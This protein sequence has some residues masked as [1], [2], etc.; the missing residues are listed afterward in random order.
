RSPP[1]SIS[2]SLPERVGPRP[3][4]LL[5]PSKRVDDRVLVVGRNEPTRPFRTVLPARISLLP[6]RFDSRLHVKRGKE[7][8]FASFS[9]PLAQCR[10]ELTPAR[11]RREQRL[12]RDLAEDELVVAKQRR[13]DRGDRARSVEWCQVP[14]LDGAL[15]LLDEPLRDLPFRLDRPRK[16]GRLHRGELLD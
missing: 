15:N 3:A 16:V 11:R 5:A 13:C 2:G 7:K 12:R 4:F 10:P 14:L 1:T 6:A 8:G 9:F